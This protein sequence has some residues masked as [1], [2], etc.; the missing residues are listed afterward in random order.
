[1]SKLVKDAADM[2]VYKISLTGGEPFLYPYL[3]DVIKLIHDYHIYLYPIFTN[4]TLIP[5]NTKL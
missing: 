2:G 5:Y 1:V 4:A 3:L